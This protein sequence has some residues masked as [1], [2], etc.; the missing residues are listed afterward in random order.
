MKNLRKYF[1]AGLIAFLP[2]ALTTKLLIVTFNFADGIL[3]KYIEPRFLKEFGFYFR[4][5]SILI[6]VFLIIVIGFLIT[7]FLGKRIFPLFEKLILQLPVVKQVYPAFKEISL[8][9]FSEEKMNFHKVVLVQYPRPGIYSI[10]FLT[11][12]VPPNVGKNVSVGM[13]YVFIPHTPSPLTGFL[14]LVPKSEIVY[15][16]ISVEEALK[17]LVSAGVVKGRSE[18]PVI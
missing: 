13:S 18:V 4:G 15:P 12:D 11:N 9:L 10:G 3:G 2:L 14:S 5:L 17:I 1:V 6:C 16:D 8:F 7:H